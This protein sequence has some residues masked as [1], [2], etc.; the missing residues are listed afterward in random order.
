MGLCMTKTEKLEGGR[1]L[2]KVSV[3]T[4]HKLTALCCSVQLTKN[5]IKN[6]AAKNIQLFDVLNHVEQICFVLKN[7]D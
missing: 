2:R 5:S 4:G 1:M 6:R 3:V 7:S